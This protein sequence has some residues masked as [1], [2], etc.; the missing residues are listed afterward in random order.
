MRILAGYSEVVKSPMPAINQADTQSVL[1][2][3]PATET[4]K[5]DPNSQRNKTLGIL[6]EEC[7]KAGALTAARFE[8][9]ILTRIG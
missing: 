1:N 6:V 5:A 9:E 3:P 4:S 2:E 8:T 7:E